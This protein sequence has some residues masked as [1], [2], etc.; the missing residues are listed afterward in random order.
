MGHASHSLA[1]P[2]AVLEPLP[3]GPPAITWQWFVPAAHV[4]P[5]HDAG[6]VPVSVPLQ[7]ALFVAGKQHG[8]FG[9]SPPFGGA[10]ESGPLSP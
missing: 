5:P 10:H 3:A 8:R 7:A 6:F 9:P 2:H 1:L 4:L